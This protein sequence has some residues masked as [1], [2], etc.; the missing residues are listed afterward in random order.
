MPACSP[1]SFHAFAHRGGLHLV[2]QLQAKN[3]HQSEV[4]FKMTEIRA[5]YISS[6]NLPRGFY[7]FFLC[8]EEIWKS[9]NS[10]NIFR[11]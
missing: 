7:S 11:I 2:E 3:K 8:Q 9:E 10:V 4:I 1:E 5:V 6:P